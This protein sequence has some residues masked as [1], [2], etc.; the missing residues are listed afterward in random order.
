MPLTDWTVAL[1]HPTSPRVRESVATS[2]EGRRQV[3]YII[4][5][6]R[7]STSQAVEWVSSAASLRF[8]HPA[9]ALA[10]AALSIRNRNVVG[11]VNYE[12][13]F[14]AFRWRTL[15]TGDNLASTTS[16]ARAHDNGSTGGILNADAHLWN[17]STGPVVLRVEM[18][19]ELHGMS[20]VNGM[21]QD[22]Q[23]GTVWTTNGLRAYLWRGSASSA[24]LL[25]PAGAEV[26]EAW[27]VFDDRQVGRVNLRATLWRDS[28]ND[29]IDLHPQGAD[30]STA[31]GAH[32]NHQVGDAFFTQG[33]Q[34]GIWTDTAESW[35]SLHALLPSRFSH[36]QASGIWTH[37]NLISVVGWGYNSQANR[38]EAL[39]WRG[40]WVSAPVPPPPLIPT[41]LPVGR[42]RK[43]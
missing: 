24:V 33:R 16:E 17:P 43:P 34:A 27:G 42:R 7:S 19:G 32:G 35:Q 20:V 1:L 4:T 26:S 14:L 29:R 31:Y 41:P 40:K 30:Y 37:E 13:T 23:V 11:R 22:R 10:S 28:A 9:N 39:L 2:V 5:T 38:R 3:G 36:S 18:D 6:G 25:H 15:N 21:H 12:S 8:K